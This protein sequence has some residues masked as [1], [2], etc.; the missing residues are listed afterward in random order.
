MLKD[1]ILKY[2]FSSCDNATSSLTVL[3]RL[4]IHEDEQTNT[5]TASFELPGIDSTTGLFLFHVG[6]WCIF[7]SPM[8]VSQT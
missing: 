1:S 8:N 3:S 4:D 7:L 5:V 6:V 2:V